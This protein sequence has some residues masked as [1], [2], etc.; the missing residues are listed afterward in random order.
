MSEHILPCPFCGVKPGGEER[1][2]DSNQNYMRITCQ[3]GASGT[4]ATSPKG[5][6]RNKAI[7]LW[8]TRAENNS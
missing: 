7:K 3:C 2:G 4:W 8:N 6:N 1:T 5:Y